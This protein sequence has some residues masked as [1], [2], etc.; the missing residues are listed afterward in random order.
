MNE[1]QLEFLKSHQQEIGLKLLR[2]TRWLAAMKYGCDEQGKTLPLGKDPENIVCEVIDDYVTYTNEQV[3]LVVSHGN[4][5]KWFHR[6]KE[7][8]P[9]IRSGNVHSHS[10]AGVRLAGK[11]GDTAKMVRTPAYAW[12]PDFE[13]DHEHD[14]MEG[15]RYLDWYDRTITLLWLKEDLTD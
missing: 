10:A 6:S 2:F 4:Q 13:G 15:S 5:I 3:A 12:L 1:G 9:W 11:A 14:I 7:F 8:W